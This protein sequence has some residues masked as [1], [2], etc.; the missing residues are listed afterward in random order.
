MIKE[1]ILCLEFYMEMKNK[2]W[3]ILIFLQF[4]NLLNKSILYKI[5][6]HLKSDVKALQHKCLLS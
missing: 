2:N 3:Y 4:Q 5:T 1:E 6:E